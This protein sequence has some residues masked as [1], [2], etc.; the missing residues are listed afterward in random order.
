MMSPTFVIGFVNEPD[1]GVTVPELLTM[2]RT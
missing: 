1:R 2:H